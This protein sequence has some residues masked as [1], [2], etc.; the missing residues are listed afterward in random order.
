MDFID[1]CIHTS[2]QQ[3][4]QQKTTYDSVGYQL[5][6]KTNDRCSILLRQQQ[7]HPPAPD[8]P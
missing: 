3:Q 2:K 1:L 8:V 7:G 4:Q 6:K 5:S